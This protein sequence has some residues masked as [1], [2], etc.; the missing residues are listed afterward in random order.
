MK[1]I[2]KPTLVERFA[3]NGEHSHWAL[4]E[5]SSGQ[6]IWHSQGLVN[7]GDF[8]DRKVAAAQQYALDE[9]KTHGMGQLTRIKTAWEKGFEKCQSVLSPL[10]IQES[11]LGEGEIPKYVA[12]LI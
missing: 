9:S 7:E 10:P 2:E 12:K 5:T 3:D 6:E 8:E 4:V 11:E 1:D